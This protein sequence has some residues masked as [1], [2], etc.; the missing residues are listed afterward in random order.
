MESVI[1]KLLDQYEHGRVSRRQL[2][3]TLAGMAAATTCAAA[4]DFETK[5]LD[6][7]SV[8]VSDPQRSAKFYQDVFGLKVLGDRSE[9]LA[10]GRWITELVLEMIG[11]HGVPPFNGLECPMAGRDTSR[12]RRR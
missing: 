4:S 11:V 1:S 8:V 9:K 5:S 10:L 7:V 6:H 3:G 2:I 12:R